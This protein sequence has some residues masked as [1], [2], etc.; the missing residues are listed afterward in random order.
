MGWHFFCEGLERPTSHVFGNLEA[1]LFLLAVILVS[2]E[3][4][5]GGDFSDL[6]RMDLE[7]ELWFLIWKW[8]FIVRLNW[9]GK[10][11]SD[12]LL[13]FGRIRTLGEEMVW[14]STD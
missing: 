5:C 8:E 9:Q 14:C 10:S 6:I 13:G 4:D 12:E 2:V 7:Q 1:S 3:V 11:W